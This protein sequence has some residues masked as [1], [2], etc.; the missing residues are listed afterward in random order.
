MAGLGRG[1]RAVVDI[2][3]S[4]GSFGDRVPDIAELKLNE[5]NM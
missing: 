4:L 3:R 2:A 1:T 5:S